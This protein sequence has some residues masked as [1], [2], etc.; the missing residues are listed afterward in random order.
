MSSRTEATSTVVHAEDL[1]SPIETLPE[2]STSRQTDP[3]ETSLVELG[4]QLLSL[5]PFEEEEMIRPTS[6]GAARVI[7]H[8]ISVESNITKPQKISGGKEP[9]S[10]GPKSVGPKSAGPKS[11]G[12]K[13]V[14]SKEP[15]SAG[16]KPAGPKTVG[17]KDPR[18]DPKTAGSRPPRPTVGGKAPRKQAVPQKRKS[19]SGSGSLNYVPTNRD[20][21]EVQA[22]GDTIPAAN[23]TTRR[24]RPGCLALQEIR[25]YQK[26]TNLL[27][28]KLPFQRLI[29][30]IAQ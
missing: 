8:T 28:Q 9:R 12:P 26:R 24:Y 10:V 30:E 27:I 16:L 6:M 14:G 25:N 4:P 5:D 20:Y 7:S 3:L 21:S 19:R 11:A 15:R 23:K 29:R 13:A 17:S 1:P 18:I 22:A 2:P